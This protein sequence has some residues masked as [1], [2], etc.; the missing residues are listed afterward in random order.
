MIPP[1]RP[2][3]T[4]FRSRGLCP[5]RRPSEGLS[6]GA[7][8]GSTPGLTSSADADLRRDRQR[9]AV[10]HGHRLRHQGYRLH[11]RE[12][13]APKA[14]RQPQ[15]HHPLRPRRRPRSSSDTHSR[16]ACT[17]SD[18]ATPAGRSS[19]SSRRRRRT[20]ASRSPSS[21]RR[22]TC[23]RRPVRRRPANLGAVGRDLNPE[24]A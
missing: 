24:L 16:P 2:N 20:Q 23:R 15:V 17:N 22:M 19:S 7:V 11:D 12:R 14:G 21:C 9:R 6:A 18:R 8:A 1:I 3:C 5:P 4:S 13:S 10:G